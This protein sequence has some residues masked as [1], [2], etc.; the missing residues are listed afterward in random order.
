MDDQ[1]VT[2]LHL[3]PDVSP[4][5]REVVVVIEEP[6]KVKAPLAFS[7]HDGGPWQFPSD[8]TLRR[9]DLYGDDDR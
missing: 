1:G 4:G 7:S 9:E 6:M 5:T 3:P 2:T 8:E